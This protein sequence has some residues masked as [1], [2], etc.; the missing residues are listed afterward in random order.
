MAL[1]FNGDSD[2]QDICTYANKLVK[3]TTS[4]FPLQEKVLYAN[5]AMRI[6]WADIFYAYG[7]WI[8]DDSNKTDLPEATA[9]LV[10]GQQ[11]YNLPVDINYLMGV[12]FQNPGGTWV[13]LEPLTLEKIKQ[14]GYAESEFYK[15]ASTPVFY[16]ATSTGIKLYPPANFSQSQSLRIHVSRDV[17]SFTTSDTTKKPG[18]DS[19]LH[20]GVP[21]Y[22]GLKYAQVNGLSVAGGVMRGGYKTGLLADWFDFRDRVKKHYSERLRQMFPPR[23][24][25]VDATR[26][27]Q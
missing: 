20:E 18:F 3:G 8:Y 4:N 21:L 19:T 16:R 13:T 26:D 14:N 6:I 27:F 7:G 23:M 5:D 1:P 17:T 12:E 9:D 2:G 11:F 22:M 25:V 10:S 15:V 24:R